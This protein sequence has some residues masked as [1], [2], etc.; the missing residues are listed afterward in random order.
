M[1]A[2]RKPLIPLIQVMA[3]EPA[4]GTFMYLVYGVNRYRG[5]LS[6]NIRGSH[7]DDLRKT[8]HAVAK[9]VLER[10][11]TADLGFCPTGQKL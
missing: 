7:G 5:Y 1:L 11:W 4:V 8:E 2:A 6:C 9:A 10:P 3:K